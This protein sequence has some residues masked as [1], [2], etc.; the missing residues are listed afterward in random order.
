LISNK[1][2]MNKDAII[3][4]KQLISKLEENVKK[5]EK[6]K[7]NNDPREFNDL[8]KQC[9]DIQKEMEKMIK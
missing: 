4:M 5:L 2:K 1:L 7:E 8:K 6:A 3:F 9:F